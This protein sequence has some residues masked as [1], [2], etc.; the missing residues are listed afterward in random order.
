MTTAA[1]MRRVSKV[2]SALTTPDGKPRVG[3]M[4]VP[5][6]LGIDEWEAIAV[7]AQ[8]ALVAACMDDTQ[9]RPHHAAPPAWEGAVQGVVSTHTPNPHR[10]QHARPAGPAQPRP[11]P[12]ATLR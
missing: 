3:V 9:V 6:I 12:K 10:S 5:A 4:R 1:L 8:A 2:Q 7:P 11:L